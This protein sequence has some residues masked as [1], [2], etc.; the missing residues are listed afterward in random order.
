MTP[1]A[2]IELKARSAPG[3][4]RASSSTLRSPCHLVCFFPDLLDPDMCEDDESADGNQRVTDS[5]DVGNG[6]ESHEI[7]VERDGEKK[8]LDAQ[9]KGCLELHEP[10]RLIDA[11]EDE[12]CGTFLPCH[13]RCYDLRHS[14]LRGGLGTGGHFHHL[15]S[16]PCF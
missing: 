1:R 11:V 2:P 14:D 8:R 15:L 16:Y 12:P 6:Y 5:P 7:V 4:L 13:S 3:G 10:L 9:S